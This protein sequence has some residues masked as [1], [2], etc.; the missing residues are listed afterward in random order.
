[1]PLIRQYFILKLNKHIIRRINGIDDPAYEP[2]R[3][4]LDTLRI[5]HN[6]LLRRPRGEVLGNDRDSKIG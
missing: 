4:E 6:G 5:R 1:M 2:P 3:A